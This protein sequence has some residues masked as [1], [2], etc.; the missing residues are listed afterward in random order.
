MIII[1]IDPGTRTTGYGLVTKTGRDVQHIDNGLISPPAKSPLP[2]RLK[3]IYTQVQKL[4]HEFK[5]QAIAL[6]DLFVAKNARSSLILGHARG[7]I[8]LAASQGH[9]PLYEYSPA[10]IKRTVVGYGQ[11]TKEQIQK[12][13]KIHLRLNEVASEDASDALAVALCHCQHSR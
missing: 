4:I 13:V 8:M 7:V 9:V 6:E 3:E 10:Q 12:L 1:G 2:D 5:P 11:A